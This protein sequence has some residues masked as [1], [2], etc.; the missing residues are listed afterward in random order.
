MHEGR[1]LCRQVEAPAP[2]D[3]RSVTHAIFWPH[4]A[5]PRGAPTRPCVA[6]G[7]QGRGA[8]RGQARAP[9]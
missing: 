1:L 5:R 7:W 9:R 3:G 6:R 8:R 4:V 2:E